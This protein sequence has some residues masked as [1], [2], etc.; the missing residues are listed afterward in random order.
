MEAANGPHTLLTRH[1]QAKSPVSSSWTKGRI[2]R[3]Q[4]SSH[5]RKLGWQNTSLH[6]KPPLMLS[7]TECYALTPFK[8]FRISEGKRFR[9]QNIKFQNTADFRS[10]PKVLAICRQFV[11]NSLG[12]SN[13]SFH[14]FACASGLSFSDMH[15]QRLRWFSWSSWNDVIAQVQ[16]FSVHAKTVRGLLA[17]PSQCLGFGKIWLANRRYTWIYARSFHT[18]DVEQDQSTFEGQGKM[19]CPHVTSTS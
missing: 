3:Q 11:G 6:I 1:S 10:L 12:K 7:C 2:S 19:K 13:Y 8:T 16:M 9:P 14:W 4:I 5:V 17:L 15:F 18:T